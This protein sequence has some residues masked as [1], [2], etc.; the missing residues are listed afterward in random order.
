MYKVADASLVRTLRTHNETVDAMVT[1]GTQV[2]RSKQQQQQQHQQQQQSNGSD[3]P[4]YKTA[5][6]KVA[7]AVG[8]CSMSRG[9]GG[10][11]RIP[12]PQSARP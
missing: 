5:A 4:Q 9:A 7:A 1:V 3:K 11:A 8:I 10:N 6:T 12:K 2:S